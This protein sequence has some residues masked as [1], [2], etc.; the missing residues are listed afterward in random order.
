MCSEKSAGDTDAEVNI[1]AKKAALCSETGAGD[2]IDNHNASQIPY[3]DLLAM[4]GCGG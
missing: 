3:A 2:G 1:A 4:L